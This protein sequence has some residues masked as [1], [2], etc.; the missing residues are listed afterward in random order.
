MRRSF[1]RLY[2]PLNSVWVASLTRRPIYDCGRS[3]SLMQVHMH[4]VAIALMADC[5]LTQCHLWLTLSALTLLL[6]RNKGHWSCTKLVLLQRL[7]KVS[8]LNLASTGY[9]KIIWKIKMF[10]SVLCVVSKFGKITSF[11]CICLQSYLK[12]CGVWS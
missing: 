6:L 4:N 8:L 7:T 5:S 11:I 1:I 9:P 10:T 2:I 12:F 3:V